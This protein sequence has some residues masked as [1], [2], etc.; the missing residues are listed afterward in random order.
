MNNWTVVAKSESLEHL[1]MLKIN[2]KE[3]C[4][5]D[6]IVLNKKNAAIK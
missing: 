6:A 5:I 1:E 4:A 2:L 3:N